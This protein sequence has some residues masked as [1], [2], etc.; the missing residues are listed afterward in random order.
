MT[1]R[2]R[3][4]QLLFTLTALC[5]FPIAVARASV[6]QFA[7]TTNLVYNGGFEAGAAGW[8]FAPNIAQSS[9]SVVT[10][11]AHGGTH[12][13]KLTNAS[14]QAPHVFGRILQTIG[15]L[16]PYTTYKIS[17]WAKGQDSG[18]VWIGG[19]PGWYLRAPFPRGTFGWTNIVTEYRT[20]DSPADFDLM[21]LTESETTSVWVDDVKMEAVS[22]DVAARDQAIASSQHQFTDAKT[23]LADLRARAETNKT[24]RADARVQLGFTVADRF[25][26]RIETG[27]PD[28]KQSVVWSRL[29]TQEIINVLKDT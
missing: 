19:G 21:I 22:A 25:I 16:Q 20:D 9:G 13:Y 1:L 2:T 6:E 7:A 12:S 11:E 5:L 27:G 8:V 4:R 17:C 23:L 10:N 26:H 28:G 14:A 3:S 15:G 29:Q 18:G 24:A